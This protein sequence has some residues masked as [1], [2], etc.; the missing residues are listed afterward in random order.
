MIN[1]TSNT[2]AI[3][4]GTLG[5]LLI[6]LQK[7]ILLFEKISF[8]WSIITNEIF[9]L[10]KKPRILFSII[11]IGPIFGLVR[12]VTGQNIVDSKRWLNYGLGVGLSGI[13]LFVIPWGLIQGFL[14]SLNTV[15]IEKKNDPN[16][17]IWMSRTNFFVTF[18]RFGGLSG[19]VV[20]GIIFLSG[21]LIAGIKPTEG[22]TN[23]LLGGSYFGLGIGL[24]LGLFTGGITCI[25]HFNL[26]QILYFKGYIPWNYAHFLD[27]AS[28]LLLMKKIGGGY[29]FYHRMLMEH[30]ANMKLEK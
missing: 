9:V 13:L 28:K 15:N 20:F 21:V 14:K 16:Q 26:R 2:A 6:I 25:Q 23:A 24:F 11:L 19:L 4:V 3:L 5:G 27:Y 29:V 7:E 22:I 17:G 1:S 12:N 18:L 10:L 8:S 30:F